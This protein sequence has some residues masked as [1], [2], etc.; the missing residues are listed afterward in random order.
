MPTPD[1]PA[2]GPPVGPEPTHPAADTPPGTP[3]VPAVGSAAW[4]V[5]GDTWPVYTPG[6]RVQLVACAGP[7]AGLLPGDAGTVTA[8]DG[9]VLHVQWDGRSSRAM[10]LDAGDVVAPED[11]TGLRACT[12]FG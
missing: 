7:Y 4:S 8:Q 3:A 9:A 11:P 10:R 1:P 2:V 5:Y 6:D 12:G